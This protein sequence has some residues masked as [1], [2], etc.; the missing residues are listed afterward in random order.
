MIFDDNVY[1]LCELHIFCDGSEIAYGAVAYLR[2][3]K[4]DSIRVSSPIFAESRLT[5][6]SNKTIKTVP[7]IELCGAKLAIEVYKIVEA[8]LQF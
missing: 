6:L 3:I 4:G 7:R 1:D 5:P 8:E 2:F